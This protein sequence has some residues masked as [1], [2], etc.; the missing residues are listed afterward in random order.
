MKA[1]DP[2]HSSGRGV[3]VDPLPGTPGPPK[4]TA[5]TTAIPTRRALLADQPASYTGP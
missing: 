2:T 3:L 1:D 4:L 5:G